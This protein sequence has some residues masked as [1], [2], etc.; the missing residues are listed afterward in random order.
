M[1]KNAA[2]VFLH[3]TFWSP[4]DIWCV[5][6]FVSLSFFCLLRLNGAPGEVFKPNSTAQDIGR[7]ES[8]VRKTSAVQTN[9]EKYKTR[10]FQGFS[11]LA[12]IF[13]WNV[14][15]ATSLVV[16]IEILRLS[17]FTEIFIQKLN[18]SLMSKQKVVDPITFQWA[19]ALCR[20]DW[21]QQ[22]R[23]STLNNFHN[24]NPSLSLLQWIHHL[25]LAQLISN[26]ATSSN[27][28]AL[29]VCQ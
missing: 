3:L 11:L 13:C 27:Q 15:K 23:G 7:T 20:N 8:L 26:A 5:I 12:G 9:W 29:R 16:V 10:L 14:L 22:L 21:K 25:F 17:W 18:N 24:F 28:I 6:C 2:V 4:D 19:K 1:T